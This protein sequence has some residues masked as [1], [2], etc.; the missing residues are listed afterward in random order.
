MSRTHEL[1]YDP[2]VP[3]PTRAE[4]RRRRKPPT[5]REKY[6]AALLTIVRPNEAGQLVP[7]IPHAKAKG[8]TVS[9]I[10]AEFEV[11]HVIFDCWHGGNHPSNLLPRPK[12]E[13]RA[14]TRNDQR[15][16]AR[17][18]RVIAKRIAEQDAISAKPTKRKQKMPHGRG[19]ATKKT[20]R[21]GVVAR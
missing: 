11:D 13:H 4:G 9:Q 8:M 21:R 1:T 10:I 18:K 6:A 5:L 14:K 2:M 7:V 20:F 3:I 12:A 17:T 16:I 15:I 19:S